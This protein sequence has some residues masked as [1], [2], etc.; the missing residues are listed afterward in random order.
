MEKLYRKVQKGRKTVYEE[1][2][3]GSVPDLS[4]GIWLVEHRP[5]SRSQTSLIWRVG[6]LKR[7]VDVVTHAA[8]L[9]FEHELTQYLMKL[10]EEGSEELQEARELLGGYVSKT[11]PIGYHNI[12]ASDLC[13]LFLR[14][15][16][17]EVEGGQK[18]SW[19]D[20]M[21]K[22]RKWSKLHT[23]EDF[24]M[25]VKVLWDFIEFLKTNNYELK[26]NQR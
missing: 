24:D 23:K 16:A 8:L 13:G 7:P 1:A 5:S 12:S 3:Y 25:N 20:L 4:P 19:A 9:S 17:L 18:I 26:Q 6:D 2:G 14:R 10:G 21:F 11:Q 15:I 22:Y